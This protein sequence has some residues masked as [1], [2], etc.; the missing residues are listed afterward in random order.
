MDYSS[1]K[2]NMIPDNTYNV[3]YI[4]PSGAGEQTANY[5]F[6][7]YLDMENDET[8]DNEDKIFAQFLTIPSPD[9]RF[10]GLKKNIK[11][12]KINEVKLISEPETEPYVLKGGKRHRSKRR[13]HRSR[14]HKK[15]KKTVKHRKY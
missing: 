15:G 14:R 4:T 13:K 7:K 1:L 5:I 3:N 8:N 12:S 6:I 2:F 11:L 10:K 9:T